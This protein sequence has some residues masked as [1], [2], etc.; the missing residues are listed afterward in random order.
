MLMSQS[1]MSAGAMGCPNCA[2]C[3]RAGVAMTIIAAQKTRCLR[4]D[5]DRLALLIDAPACDRVVRVAAA[6]SAL[7]HEPRARRL[8]HAGLVSGSALQHGGTAAPSP[9]RSE[10]SKRF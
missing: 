4:I 10:T 6:R 8:H 2:F 1:A 7:R 9:G 3:D 5:I